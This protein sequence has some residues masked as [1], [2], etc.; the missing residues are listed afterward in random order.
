MRAIKD[1]YEVLGINKESS[2]AQIKTAYR[3]LAKKYHPDKN[4]GN[5][6]AEKKFKEITEAYEVLSNEQKRKQYDQFRDGGFRGFG[7]GNPFDGG[8][9][10]GSAFGFENMDL[11]ELFNSFFSGGESMFGSTTREPR[12][13]AVKGEDMYVKL[14]VPF[15]VAA[16]GGKSTITLNK[17]SSCDSCNGS[18][19]KAGGQKKRCSYC[20]G[21]G[22]IQNQKGTFSFQRNCPRCMGQGV[23]I[24]SPCSVCHGNGFC[25]TKRKLSVSIPSGIESGQKIKLSGEGHLGSN[26]GSSGDLY[27]EVNVLSDSPFT[28]DGI[29]ILSE[30]TIDLK[31]A[32]LGSKAIIHTLQGDVELK[33]PAGIQPGTVLRIPEQGIA[34][35]KRKGDHLVKIQVHIPGKLTRKQKELLEEFS[36]LGLD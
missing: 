7:A 29:N 10:G 2:E 14:D 12:S 20:D 3:D 34:Q 22:Q 23:L 8:S 17:D 18:G 30:Y 26:G 11:S 32:M 27:I 13:R 25:K 31:E 33:I 35:G 19:I 1:Y 36:S 5:K 28:R 21:T 9:M 24:D 6:E 15:D 4:P 16:K